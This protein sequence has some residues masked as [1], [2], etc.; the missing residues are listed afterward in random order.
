VRFGVEVLVP[1]QKEQNIVHRII[2]EELCIGKIEEA[3]HQACLK[4]IEGLRGQGAQG[5]IL[6]CTVLPLLIRPRDVCVSLFDTTRMHAE[7][8]VQLALEE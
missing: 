4:M 7:A 1:E 5:I 6:G 3:F 2:Y 8:A